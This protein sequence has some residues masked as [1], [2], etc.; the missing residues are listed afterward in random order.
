MA[1]T[2]FTMRGLATLTLWAGFGLTATAQ[3]PVLTVEKAFET[4]P[5]Q[6]GVTVPTPPPDQLARFRIEPIQNPPMTGSTIGYVVRDGEN[7]PVRQFVSFDNKSFNIVAF[8]VDGVEAY[9]EVY[10]PNPAN[11]FQF[12]W[13]GPNGSKWGVDRDRDGRIDHWGVISPEEVSQ[14]LLQ[15]VI[16]KD[17]KRLEAL[18]VTRENLDA[19]KLPPAEAAKITER[20][21]KA[22]QK[23]IAAADAL[24]LTPEAKWVHL[25]TGVPHVTPADA[26]KGADDLTAH[27][28]AI[29]LIQDG[30]DTK[31][32]QT[33]ELV[34]IGRAWKVVDGPTAGPGQLVAEGPTGGNDDAPRVF[35]ETA[36][37]VKQLDKLDTEAG[38]GTT[39]DALAAYYGKR[40]AILEQIVQK[41]PQEHQGPW[42][43]LLL[44]SLAAAAEGGKSDGPH[45]ARLKQLAGVLKG[46][47]QSPLAAYSA[48]RVLTAENGIALRE[49]GNKEKELQAAQE[50]WRA[51]LE[52]FVKAYPTSADA[53]E[54]VLRLAISY[55]FAGKDAE[56]KAKQ[57][58]EHLVK[59]YSATPTAAGHVAKAQG[60]LRRLESEGKA[61]D[62]Q[63]P[64]LGTNQPFASA[65]ITGK[66]I[67]VYYWASWVSTLE[68]DAKKLKE[69]ATT[70]GP[71][72]L[73]I[74]T[75]CLDDDPQ[76]GVKAIQA[77]QLPGTHLHQR[78]G[79]DA[80][81]LATAYGIHL[82]PHAFVVGKDGK[83]VNKNAAVLTLDG[84]LKPLMPQ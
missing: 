38:P 56:T 54:C 16:A 67:V 32:L 2:R 28:N 71:K 40:A 51:G 61:F 18:L 43:K 23:L 24:K 7:K 22:A 6:P 81:P 13:L 80:S 44:D 59:T 29:V 25:E 41:T 34:L 84:D 70:Y 19:I 55:E 15:A 68:Q 1:I 5:R 48:F 45:L 14:E 53:P 49:A 4:K 50:K 9:R 8:Y 72:G 12:R 64:V 10:D 75:V 52:E 36:E 82:P 77:V 69:L 83:V 37:L 26:F 57:W 65:R 47:P 20:T 27:K 30:K 58:Y 74:V 62:L 35:P 73:E 66:V 17:A 39:P 46:N 11:P 76:L 31:F 42:V 79:V 60:S 21:G 33:G 63:G 78:G 3:P